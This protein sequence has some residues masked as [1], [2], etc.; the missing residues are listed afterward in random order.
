[1]NTKKTAFKSI[2][3][4][5]L[6]SA[7]PAHAIEQNE[8]CNFIPYEQL[9]P[10]QRVVVEEKVKALLQHIKIDFKSVKVGI[11]QDGNVVF[12]GRTDKELENVVS[13]PTCWTK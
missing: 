8:D 11:D 10:E 3:T 7:F 4:A 1:M 9:Q 13:N 6:L 12:K 2:V 5:A